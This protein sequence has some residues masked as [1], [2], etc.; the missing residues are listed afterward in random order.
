M[1]ASLR[2]QLHES[3]MQ[4]QQLGDIDKAIT[5][6]VHR[7]HRSLALAVA[8][9]AACVALL[10][11]M[12]S[13]TRIGE[14]QPEPLQPSPAP[15]VHGWPG[16][17]GA[18]AGVYSWDAQDIRWMHNV[19]NGAVGIEVTF[20]TE[21]PDGGDG[22][23]RRFGPVS[24]ASHGDVAPAVVAGYHGTYR[25]IDEQRE[26]WVVDID[27]TMVSILLLAPAGT[28]ET[29]LAAAHAVIESISSLP[30]DQDPGFMLTFEL[31]RGWD[32]G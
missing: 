32:S 25:Q 4:V 28:T 30:V 7:R 23:L 20:A 22:F 9:S 6:G 5:V 14:T 31:P 2:E 21:N 8:V 3:A 13:G 10:V 26:E 12:M 27:G 29:E 1:S 15:V 19:S 17:R 16:A 24:E 11:A 18:R